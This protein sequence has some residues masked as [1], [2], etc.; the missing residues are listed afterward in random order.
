MV[1]RV[2]HSTSGITLPEFVLTAPAPVR[3][4]Y[5]YALGHP[6]VLQYIPCYCGCGNKG[7]TSNQDCFIDQRLPAGRVVYD[8][9]GSA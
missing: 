6:E 1:V 4:A 5:A 7:H 3:E 2:E 8:P 9:M